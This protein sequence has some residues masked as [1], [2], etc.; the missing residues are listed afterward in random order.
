VIMVYTIIIVV[1]IE[2]REI[3]TKKKKSM[4]DPEEESWTMAGSNPNLADEV[5]TQLILQLG[6]EETQPYRRPTYLDEIQGW[7]D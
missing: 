5:E 2:I 6:D 7:S 3:L 4:E 1:E